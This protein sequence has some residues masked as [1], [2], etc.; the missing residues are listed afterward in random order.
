LERRFK[1]ERRGFVDLKG[2]GEVETYWLV[3]RHDRES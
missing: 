1:L 2:K 3:G